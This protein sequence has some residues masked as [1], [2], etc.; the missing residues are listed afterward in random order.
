M[1]AIGGRR[2]L[3]RKER[4]EKGTE[5]ALLPHKEK[6]TPYSQPWLGRSSLRELQSRSKHD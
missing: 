3:C 5:E 6:E 4:R 1:G 2:E